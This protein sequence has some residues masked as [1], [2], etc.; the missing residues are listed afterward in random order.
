MKPKLS[1]GVCVLISLAL[2]LFGLGFG[3][4]GGFNQERRQV[5]EGLTG[6]NGLND[7]LAYRGADGL[8]LCVVARR[9][10][11]GD[12][13]V[14]KLAQISRTLTDEAISPAEKN[15]QNRELETAVTAVLQKLQV[16]P[17][18]RE[19]QRDQRYAAMLQSDL[20]SLAQ[21]GAKEAYNTSAVQFNQKLSGTPMGKLAALLGV[22]PCETLD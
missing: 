22:Q 13:A 6:S 12:E 4:V 19:S 16:S 3:T 1:I 20:E 18:Y 21:S 9:H 17:S 5:T 14:E 8:N 10:L 11:Q 15:D 7:T 2:V